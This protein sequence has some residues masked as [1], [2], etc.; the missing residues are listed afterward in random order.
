MSNRYF[1]ETP[2]TGDNARL[3]GAEAHHLAHVMRAKVGDEVTLF[4]GSGTEFIARVVAIGRSSVDLAVLARQEI[5]RELPRRITLAVS[6]P[7]GDRQRWL[8]EKA[9]ELGMARLVPLVTERSVAQ[10]VASALVRL[11]RSVIEA[12]KQC[13]RN[14]LMQISEPLRWRDF[15]AGTPA[16]AFRWIAHP[17]FRRSEPLSLRERVGVRESIDEASCAA[18]FI[19]AVGPEGGFTDDEVR[20]ALDA[21]WQSLS[22]GPRILRVETAAIALAS[23]AA[24]TCGGSCA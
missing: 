3:D 24:L 1:V 14:R 2:I 5:D 8:V 12:S 17:S 13:G 20:K 10:P 4:D 23:W 22:L 6:L 9:T 7:K 18:E 21:G 16:N 11:E 15:V 19:F